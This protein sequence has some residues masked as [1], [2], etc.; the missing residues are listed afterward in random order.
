M[1][2]S[3]NAGCNLRDV[4]TMFLRVNTVGVSG[5]VGIESLCVPL[6][7]GEDGK[8]AAK[9]DTSRSDKRHRE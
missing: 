2:L 5:L 8:T 4:S 9:R 6:E 7:K 3:S 1:R